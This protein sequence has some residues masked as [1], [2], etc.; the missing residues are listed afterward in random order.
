MSKG[1]TSAFKEAK[2]KQADCVDYPLW[3]GTKTLKPK[4]LK[5]YQIM[6]ESLN[7]TQYLTGRQ[8]NLEKATKS[9]TT[10]RRT[11]QEM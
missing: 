8:S 3:M 5:R 6:T 10:T 4:V 7:V 1:H 9:L 11:T 2:N